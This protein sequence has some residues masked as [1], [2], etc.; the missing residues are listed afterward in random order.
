MHITFISIKVR[1]ICECSTRALCLFGVDGAMSLQQALADLKAA[2]R[3]DELPP[4]Y[5]LL[6]T[7][8]LK[9][10]ILASNGLRIKTQLVDSEKTGELTLKIIEINK[11]E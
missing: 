10:E 2:K 4:I 8:K 1:D 5:T 3:L 9:P 6:N 11:Y 7:S